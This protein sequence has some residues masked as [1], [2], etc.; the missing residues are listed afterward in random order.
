MVVNQF[1]SVDVKT[2]VK[3]LHIDSWARLQNGMIE[4]YVHPLEEDR[5]WNFLNMLQKTGSVKDYS[6]K[7][8]QSIVK[9]DNNVTEKISS[10]ATWRFSKTTSA[11]YFVWEW[12]MDATLSCSGKKRGRSAGI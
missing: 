3:T 10:D 6:E 8:L 1:L 7:F 2:W 11:R 5:A 12:S 9:V 4:Y